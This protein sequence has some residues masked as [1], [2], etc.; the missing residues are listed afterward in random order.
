MKKLFII[1]DEKSICNALKYAF[2]DEYEVFMANNMDEFNKMI[3]G[4]RPSLVLLD[5]RFG[6]I[7]GLD[8]LERIKKIYPDVVVIIMTA[9]GTIESS[10]QAIKKGAYDYILKPLNLDDLRELV[11]KA[12]QYQNIHKKIMLDNYSFEEEKDIGIIGKTVKVKKVY[13]MVE[14]VK[15]LDVNVLIQGE[16]GTGKELVA[17][18]IHYNGT[19]KDKPFV[20][21][22]CG[23]IPEHLVESEL[24]G[25]EKGAFTGANESKKGR[26]E[27]ANKGT[28]FLDEIGEMNPYCQVKLLRA[29]QQREIFPL[30]GTSSKKIDVRII[31]ATNKDL[32]KEVE[33]GRFRKD[34]FFRLNVVPIYVPSL[35]ERK[36]DIPL[37][38]EHFIKKANLMYNLS[39]KEITEGALEKLKSHNYIGNIRELEN[40]IYRACIFSSKG[41]I[42]ETCIPDLSPLDEVYYDEDI[43]PIKLG[44]KLEEAE[45]QLI[46]NTLDYVDGN[47]AKAAR[48][49]GI[50]ERSIHY[51]VKNYFD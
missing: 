15:N 48:I 19:R 7:S 13:E 35:N 22:N 23:A 28:L 44:T 36:E 20:A 40:I 24:F 37:L 25:Y 31:A 21:V 17:M 26:F 10:I 33:E 47:K 43:I 1:D 45:K 42:D 12:E 29:L 49:L 2:E 14:R 50:S 11:K 6:S 39:I 30:G 27:L 32:S 8:L 34:L 5:L 16:S 51:K 4:N 41:F 46:I 18:A 9:Y 38:V 3:K